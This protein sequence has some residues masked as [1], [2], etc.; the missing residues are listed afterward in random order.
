MIPTRR[1]ALLSAASGLT[2]GLASA[3]RAQTAPPTPAEA[4]SSGAW[5]NRPVRIIVPAPGGGGTADT[6]AR[7]FS[8]EMEKRVGQRVLVDNRG[9]ANG[10]IGALAGARATPDGYTILWSWAGTLATGPALY[11]DLPFDPEKDFEP[12]ALIGNVPNVLV[13][14]KDLPIHSLQEFGDYARA[15]PNGIN[16]GSTGNGSSMHLAG[17][18]YKSLTG[19]QMVH[20]PYAAPA[21]GVTDL[22]AGRI[23]AMF[24]LITGVA[25]QVRAGAVTP[26][27]ILDDRRSPQ[28]PDVP[29]TAE[30][31]MPGL[32]FGTW[33]GLFLPKGVDPAL[34]RRIN[35]VAN[36][37]LAD[38][39]A[40]TR[41]EE[42]GMT[43][44]GGDP[45]RLA[46]FLHEE[47]GRH[48]ALVRQSGARNE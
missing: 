25:P 31:G 30:L 3:A 11:K 12:V 27:A 38:P 13:V 17:E 28:L 43:P 18:L 29:T 35:A 22:L 34:L 45:A 8:Q 44:L 16:F 2:L 26:I 5:P 23:Q 21:A 42:Q 6:L 41:F 4:P 15:H 19:A 47:I 36:E 20:V 32:V 10:N 40:R 1:R 33:F 39:A 37:I 48:A 24:N 14:N 46:N 7:V 9:G